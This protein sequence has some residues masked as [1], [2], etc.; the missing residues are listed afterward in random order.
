MSFL[1]DIMDLIKNYNHL[2]IYLKT[3]RNNKNIHPDYINYFTKLNEEYSNLK[4]ID[5]SISA[6]SIINN[7]DL[8]ISI[9]YTSTA[10]ISN[11]FSVK[12]IYYDPSGKLPKNSNNFKLIELINDKK[13]LEKCLIKFLK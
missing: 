1:E 2:E 6:Q 4:I 3:K 11:S 9:P 5:G 7:S 12:S 13:K 8:S 10:L